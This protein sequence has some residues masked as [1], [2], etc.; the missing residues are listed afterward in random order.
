M[1]KQQEQLYGQSVSNKVLVYGWY[2]K[3]N[4]GD[5]LFC[6]VF[7]KLFPHINF[8]FTDNI[9]LE[10]IKDVSAIF[11]GGGSFLSE[12]PAIQDECLNIVKT[13]KIIYVGV[14]AE[15][16]IHPIHK[17]LISLARLVALRSQEGAEKVKE[18][19][20][21][22]IFIPDLVYYFYKGKNNKSENKSILIVPNISV[23]PQNTDPHWKFNSWNNFKFEFSQ[24]LDWLIENEYKI[25]FLSMCKNSNQNDDWAVYEIISCM[26]HRDENYLIDTNL[27]NMSD[28]AKLFETYDVVISQRYHG[29]IL[30]EILGI[31]F[32]SIH[33]HNKLKSSYLNTGKFISYYSSSKQTYID[34]FYLTIKE[35]T[36]QA[37]AIESDIFE[38][39]KYKI[40]L[41]LER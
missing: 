4:I 38:A 36:N 39:L 20:E 35:K 8:I 23:V 37:I 25:N 16:E 10:N 40:N 24:F 30:S 13:K 17:D 14:G 12:A 27:L 11:I 9:T 29:I 1:C 41:I 5:D 34:Q 19:N 21:N 26:K 3:N 32:I 22:V 6:E 31:P 2:N 15:T 28:I 7:K 18:L 33:H